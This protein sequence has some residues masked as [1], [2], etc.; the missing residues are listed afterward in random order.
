LSTL[1]TVE[2]GSG[3][4]PGDVPEVEALV[5]EIHGLLELLW[6]ERPPLPAANTPTI[7]Q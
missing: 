1:A 5:T 6:S 4:K 2:K 7:R 3:Q